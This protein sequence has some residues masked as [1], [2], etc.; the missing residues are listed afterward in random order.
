[1]LF[2]C[3]VDEVIRESTIAD[4]GRAEMLLWDT[5]ASADEVMICESTLGV[6]SLVL[7]TAD[8]T[9]LAATRRVSMRFFRD[10]SSFWTSVMAAV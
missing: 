2:D 6:V 7:T 10:L 4:A 1:M 5:G 3:E 8:V 9:G